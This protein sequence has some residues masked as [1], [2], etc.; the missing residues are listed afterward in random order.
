MGGDYVTEFRAPVHGLPMVLEVYI[1]EEDT[2]YKIE[3]FTGNPG[4]LPCVLVNAILRD[5]ASRFKTVKQEMNI[6][7]DDGNFYDS[8]TISV[9][10]E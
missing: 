10:Y 2:V 5:N 1:N 4:R 8:L 3:Y 7:A 9:L 6:A